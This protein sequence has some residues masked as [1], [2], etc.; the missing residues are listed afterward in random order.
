MGLHKFLEDHLTLFKPMP[1]VGSVWRYYDQDPFNDY[2]AAVI[3]VKDDWVKYKNLTT[4]IISTCDKFEFY[5]AFIPIK[6]G[7]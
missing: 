7:E 4:S 2:R 5:R 3:D 6:D 1:A